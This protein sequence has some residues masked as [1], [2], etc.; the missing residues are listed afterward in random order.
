[1]CARHE[2]TLSLSRI[3]EPRVSDNKPHARNSDVNAD[4][5]RIDINRFEAIAFVGGREQSRCGIWLGGLSRTDGISVSYDGVG[6]DNS[7]GESMSVRDN[8]CSLLFRTDRHGSFR[9]EAKSRNSLTRGLPNTFRA[10][11][12]RDSGN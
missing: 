11:S 6:S 5:W 12:S 8:V 3:A 2:S 10:F 7:H 1:M 9:A 4:S